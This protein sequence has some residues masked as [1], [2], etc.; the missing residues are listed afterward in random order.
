VDVAIYR[1]PIYYSRRGG[2]IRVHSDRRLAPHIRHGFVMREQ[3]CGVTAILIRALALYRVNCRVKSLPPGHGNTCRTDIVP[4]S[5]LAETKGDAIAS[6]NQLR[7]ARAFLNLH[8][9][10]APRS[11]Y[12]PVLI[13]E[14]S[15]A[16][17][18]RE[19]GLPS[20]PLVNLDERAKLTS[21]KRT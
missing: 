13:F 19:N 6:S 16:K 9:N 17:R 5:H 7:C 8:F 1:G 11:S 21:I 18:K 4:R 2:L 20:L 10:S 15:P 3:R 14:L 12:Y